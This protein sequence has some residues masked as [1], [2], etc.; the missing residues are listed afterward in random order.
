M[1]GGFGGIIVDMAT[2]RVSQPRP[3]EISLERWRACELV[4]KGW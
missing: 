1:K 3:R 2:I 4:R